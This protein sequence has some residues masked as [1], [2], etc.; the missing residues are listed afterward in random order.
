M[1]EQIR[2]IAQN[3]FA[4]LTIQIDS[5]E[6]T[7]EDNERHIYTIRLKTPDSKI[8]IGTHGQTLDHLKHILSRLVEKTL[9][10]SVILHVEINDYLQAKDEKLFRYIDEKISYVLKIKKEITLGHLS[11]Y[12][13][14]K[15]HTYISEKQMSEIST[16]STGE[17]LERVIHIGFNSST[18]KSS[19]DV[20]GVGI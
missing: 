14:K 1:N 7:T 13:R 10:T 17:G 16:Y 3:F 15:V 9:E 19:I 6:V 12:E 5:L 2:Q 8:L 4:H 18:T 20:D 11:A